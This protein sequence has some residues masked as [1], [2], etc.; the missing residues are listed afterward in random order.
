[1][2]LCFFFFFTKSS[3]KVNDSQYIMIV[4][5]TVVCQKETPEP[6]SLLNK[7]YM[8]TRRIKHLKFHVQLNPRKEK[9]TAATSRCAEVRRKYVNKIGAG[10]RHVVT[11]H[12]NVPNHLGRP[13]FRFACRCLYHK[14]RRTAMCKCGSTWCQA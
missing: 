1:M 4:K 10:S 11:F 13:L 3:L 7:I 12:M 5:C 14:I 6:L 8:K 9:G 2:N